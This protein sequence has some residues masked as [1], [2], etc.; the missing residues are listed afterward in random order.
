MKFKFTWGKKLIAGILLAA[1]VVGGTA[2]PA[3]A[4]SKNH[5]AVVAQDNYR[6]TLCKGFLGKSYGSVV[7]GIRCDCSG[8]TRAALNRLESKGRKGANATVLT[9]N[10]ESSILAANATEVTFCAILCIMRVSFLYSE[11][12]SVKLWRGPTQKSSLHDY[13]CFRT[14]PFYAVRTFSQL[15]KTY[16]LSQRKSA[17][18]AAV[19]GTSYKYFGCILVGMHKMECTNLWYNFVLI[20]V[21]ILSEYRFSHSP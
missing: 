21:W 16:F 8:Y 4:A 14:F 18:Y 1:V 12:I 11:R 2:A 20:Q 6:K 10:I 13:F 5:T 9:A 3:E 17:N 7:D 19:K 15:G